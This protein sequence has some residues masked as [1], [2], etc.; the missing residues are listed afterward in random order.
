MII[1]DWHK[2][3]YSGHDTD[4]IEV[5]SLKGAIAIRDSKRCDYGQI[6]VTPAAWF[7]LKEAV[8]HI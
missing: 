2:S 5:A 6:A 7:A 4:C 1:I 8:R 3:T